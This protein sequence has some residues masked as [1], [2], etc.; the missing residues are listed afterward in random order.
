[1]D[2]GFK[3]PKTNLGIRIRILKIP[4]VP[5]FRENKQMLLFC[6][7]F[8]QKWIYQFKIKKTNVEIR[9][10]IL[11]IPCMPTF[12]QNRTTL[13]F[14]AQIYPKRNLKLKIHKTNVGIRISILEISFSVKRD[15]FNFFCPIFSQKGN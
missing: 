10:N 9:I 13:A 6:P 8:G 7:K 12:R 11:E 2:S 5:I 4:S 1:M 15:N 14:L 3:I